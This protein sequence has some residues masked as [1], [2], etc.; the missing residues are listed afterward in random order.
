MERGLSTGPIWQ[1]TD[2]FALQPVLS[3]F[4][5]RANFLLPGFPLAQSAQLLLPIG[6]D[7]GFSFDRARKWLHGVLRLGGVNPVLAV[8]HGNRILKCR[9]L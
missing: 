1:V 3:V 6:L 9:L 7:A 8:A 4:L 5:G 2:T